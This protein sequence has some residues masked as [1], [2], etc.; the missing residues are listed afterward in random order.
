MNS[1]YIS[2]ITLAIF[3]SVIVAIS[4]RVFTSLYLE[5][6]KS[7]DLMRIERIVAGG[8]LSKSQGYIFGKSS[9]RQL[10]K[11]KNF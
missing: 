6:K 1:Q 7:R 5:N 10:L 2:L 11:S 8:L 4:L 9:L 3:G